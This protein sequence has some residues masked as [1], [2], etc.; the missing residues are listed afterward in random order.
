MSFPRS[1]GHIPCYYNYKPSA[2]RGYLCDDITPLYPFGF[3][4][5]YTN[6]II[7][8]VRLEKEIIGIDESVHVYLDIKNDGEMA[9]EEVVQMY[10]RDVVSSVTRPVKELKGFQKVYLKLGESKTIALKITPEQLA[11]T[12][13][14]KKYVVEPGDFEIMIGNS[15]QDSDLKKIILNV[16]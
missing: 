9:G 4:L 15:S 14:E 13:I 5:S 3:G 11:F 16:K 2:R 1:V 6:F 8:N 12:N 7:S 10:I